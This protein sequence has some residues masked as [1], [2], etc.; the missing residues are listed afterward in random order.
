[1]QGMPIIYISQPNYC[2]VMLWE[3]K[4]KREFILKIGDS[5]TSF[6]FLGTIGQMQ[7]DLREYMPSLV[8]FCFLSNYCP[9]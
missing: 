3:K 9:H 2:K 7:A 4:R 1:M 8:S 6:S 5:A